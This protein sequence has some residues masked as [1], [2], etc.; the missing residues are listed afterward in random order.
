[1][2]HRP[3]P[4]SQRSHLKYIYAL[5]NC[6]KTLLTPLLI[7]KKCNKKERRKIFM[8]AK[9]FYDERNIRVQKSPLER[10]LELK[11]KEANRDSLQ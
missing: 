7:T 9:S 5:N 3:G 1:M 6:S 2:Q 10:N 4:S 8:T 11:T